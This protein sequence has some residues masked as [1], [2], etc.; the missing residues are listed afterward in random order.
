MFKLNTLIPIFAISDVSFEA[1]TI[2]RQMLYHLGT[3]NEGINAYVILSMPYEI[4]LPIT[5]IMYNN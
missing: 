4:C 3:V 1:Q 2:P 5:K